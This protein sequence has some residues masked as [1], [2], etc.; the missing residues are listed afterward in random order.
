[1]RL[2]V[3]CLALLLAVPAVPVARAQDPLEGK[4]WKRPG[5]ASQLGLTAEQQDQIEKTFAELTAEEKA[6]YSHRG[7]A[8]RQFLDWADHLP[9]LHPHSAT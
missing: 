8:F 9:D 5:I 1:M 6:Q 7:A 3:L 2:R 4:W